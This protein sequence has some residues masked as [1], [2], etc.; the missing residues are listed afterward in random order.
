[1]HANITLFTLLFSNSN[2]SGISALYV[3]SLHCL[4]AEVV[5]DP[6]FFPLTAAAGASVGVW[7]FL[8]FAAL[9]SAGAG[10]QP[11]GDGIPL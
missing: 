3:I 6:P 11:T 8:L 1:M 7:A 10:A 2:K 5:A 9:S 4:V